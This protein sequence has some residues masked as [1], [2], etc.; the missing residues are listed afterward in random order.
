MAKWT[1]YKIKRMKN[2][3]LW[4][5]FDL[6]DSCSQRSLR[7]E[8]PL[9]TQDKNLYVLRILFVTRCVHSRTSVT[10]W[11]PRLVTICLSFSLSTMPVAIILGGQLLTLVLREL[12]VEPLV[13][14]V[15]LRTDG[16]LL[17]FEVTLGSV[18][19]VST[20]WAAVTTTLAASTGDFSIIFQLNK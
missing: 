7:M 1:F 12:R 10:T 13:T 17:N 9:L 14:A 11:P 20:S 15:D 3:A 19:L 5:I 6:F 4:N 16:F 18:S 2:Y 8:A